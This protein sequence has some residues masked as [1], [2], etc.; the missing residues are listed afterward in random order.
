[1]PL[2]PA[3][4]FIATSSRR[5]FLSRSAATPRFSI[6]GWRK[7][8]S[9]GRRPGSSSDEVTKT[10]QDLT[11][12]GSTMGT[13]AY[14]SPEQVAGM[15]LDQ[16]SDLFSF[17]V[18]LYEMAT[19]RRPFERA[20]PGATF[21]AI[22]HESADSAQFLE[23][24]TS[25]A[26]RQRSLTKRCKSRR[27]RATSTLRRCAADLDRLK[28]RHESGRLE[29]ASNEVPPISDSAASVLTSRLHPSPEGARSWWQAWRSRIAWTG[30][31]H[32]P[33]A[34]QVSSRDPARG[35]QS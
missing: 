26:G 25:A 33:C 20:T 21:G 24:A 28:R 35:R 12:S 32:S 2:T 18:V 5:T 4:L 19:G 3:A 10:R 29:V 9:R 17:G 16:R 15:P 13:V 34:G 30:G 31:S 8:S 14:M 1:M 27:S 23:C 22:L 11:T 7:S 6:L